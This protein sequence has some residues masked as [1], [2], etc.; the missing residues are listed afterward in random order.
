MRTL[1]AEPSTVLV[2]GFIALSIAMI[3]G[4]GIVTRSWKAAGLAAAWGALTGGIALSGWTADFDSFP[5]RAAFVLVPVFLLVGVISVTKFGGTLSQLPLKLLVGFQAF[6]IIVEIL[7]HRAAVEGVA[8]AQLSWDGYNFDIATGI[9][10]LLL[11][12]FVDRCPRW[13]ILAWNTLGLLLVLSVVTVAIL[14]LPTPFQ[15]FKPDNVW[16]GFFP[17][18]WLPTILVAFA[19]AGHLAL[20]RKLLAS[21]SSSQ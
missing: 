20:F 1:P 7:I 14:S 21:P 2:I 5:P 8:P 11:M 17:F 13:L 3:I 19:I 10:A 9:T 18:I 4:L 16:V 6:R 15:Q 12:F